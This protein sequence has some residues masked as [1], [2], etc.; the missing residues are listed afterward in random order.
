MLAPPMIVEDPHFDEC[1]EKLSAALGGTLV[2]A[3]T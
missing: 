2:S 1:I 3:S